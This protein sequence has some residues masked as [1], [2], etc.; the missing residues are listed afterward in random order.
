MRVVGEIDIY[1][2]RFDS[3]VLPEKVQ[4][5]ESVCGLVKRSFPI[6]LLADMQPFFCGCDCTVYLLNG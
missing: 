5:G 4:I 1:Q 6:D 2:P 3:A